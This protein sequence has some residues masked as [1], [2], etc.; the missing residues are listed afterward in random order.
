VDRAGEHVEAI[1]RYSNH[2][3]VA[4]CEFC[5]EGGP[6]AQPPLLAGL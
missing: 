3:G 6:G 2:I 4:R 1:A 5:A